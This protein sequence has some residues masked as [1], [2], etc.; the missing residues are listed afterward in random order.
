MKKAILIFGV[1]LIPLLISGQSFHLEQDHSTLQVKNIDKSIAFYKS[2]LHLEEIGTPWPEDLNIRFFKIGKYQQ[3]HIAHVNFGDV[4]LNKVM[5]LAFNVN[6]FD[7]YLKFLKDNK[8]KYSNFNKEYYKIEQRPDGVRQIY[9]Q[10]PDGYWI[11][12][13]DAKH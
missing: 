13:N 11:E 3:L 7:G 10:D 9:F 2:I 4:K 1:L 5:H 12:I 8:I 6:N